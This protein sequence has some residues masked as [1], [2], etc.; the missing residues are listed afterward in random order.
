MLCA[1][2]SSSEISHLVAFPRFGFRRS[3]I[4]RDRELLRRSFATDAPELAVVGLPIAPIGK[5]SYDLQRFIS[6]YT[7]HVLHETQVTAIAFQ[8]ERYTSAIARDLVMQGAKQS[9][10][11]DSLARKR[12]T[13]AVRE[14][15]A[16]SDVAYTADD[17]ARCQLCV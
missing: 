2:F 8:D 14:R 11:R 9:F 7:Q 3:T 1:C 13:D 17:H 10:R 15:G 5:D 12:A 16:H 4:E 6:I